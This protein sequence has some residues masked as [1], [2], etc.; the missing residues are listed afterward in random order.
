MAFYVGIILTAIFIGAVLPELLRTLDEKSL[1]L[2]KCPACFGINMGPQLVTG[3]VKLET[4]SRLTTAFRLNAKNVYLADYSGE[5]V[6][7]QF[8]TFLMFN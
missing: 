4:W 7:L 2:D 5:K 8:F 3:Q 1:E 6:P